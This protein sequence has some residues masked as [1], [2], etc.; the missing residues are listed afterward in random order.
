[1]G[2]QG[3]DSLTS[4][5][6]EKARGEEVE[7]RHSFYKVHS[8]EEKSWQELERVGGILSSRREISE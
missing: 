5:A 3:G 7:S 2:G 6:R 1:M 8:K 4:G